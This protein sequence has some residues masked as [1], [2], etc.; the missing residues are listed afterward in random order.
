MCGFAGTAGTLGLD[1][2][3][4]LDALAHRGPDGGGEREHTDPAVWLGH[5]RLAIL[6]PSPAGNQPMSSRDGRWHLVYNGEVYGH[7]ALRR[8]L[9]GPFQGSSDTETL[10]ELLAAEGVHETLRRLDGMY[11]FAAFDSHAGQLHLARDPFGIKPLYTARTPDGGL[12]FASEVQALLAGLGGAGG[13]IGG[14]DPDALQSFLTLRFIPSPATLWRGIRRLPPG[15]LLTVELGSGDQALH[16][17]TEPVRDR[18]VGSIEDAREAYG[19]VLSKAVER[20]LLSD[21]PVGL[22]LSGGVDS[23][24]LAA[25]VVQQGKQLPTFTVGF[26]DDRPECEI[27][28]ARETAA[29]LGLPHHAVQVTPESLWQSM[30][31]AT[32]VV[33]EPLATTSMAAMLPLAEAAR[34][35]VTVVL[36]GQGNDELWGGYRRYQAELLRPWLPVHGPLG[37]LARLA[38]P[39]LPCSVERGLRCLAPGDPVSRFEEAYALFT[40]S[41]RRALTG[42]D[43]DGAAAERI[44]YWRDW[45]EGA[46]P[47]PAEQMMRI[48]GRLGLAHDLLLY[49]DKI[50]M[51][52]ALEARVPM[53]DLELT[54][55]VESFPLRYRVQLGR[56]KIVH[57][58]TLRGLLPD[59]VLRRPKRGFEIPFGA[60]A[61]G[62]WKQPIEA[63]LMDQSAKLG[64]VLGRAFV[65]RLWDQHQR[66]RGDRSRQLMGLIGLALWLER[67]GERS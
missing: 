37:A 2:E 55:L 19:H 27:A 48:D 46:A 29:G 7:R 36:T 3:A 31:R 34:E 43:G 57:R 26:G 32:A 30:E 15:H 6:D 20:Q 28:D 8:P 33:E 41:Q 49:S 54:R 58:H 56:T 42:D 51:S 61:R 35:Q 47:H 23:A 18:F 64:T 39:S 5:R 66:R 63:L 22:L 60:W 25:L 53:L 12:A 67:H 24:A 38:P 40:S 62:P 17:F 1:R 59:A 10:V 9:R 14:L 50:S 65:R 16:R 4:M 52:C 45:L 11:A 44:A 13:G 21:V